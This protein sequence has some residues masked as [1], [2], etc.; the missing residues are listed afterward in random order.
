[1]G[2][3]P[4]SS[5]WS[6]VWGV[7]MPF[8]GVFTECDG[9]GWAYWRPGCRFR[10]CGR[11]QR[12]GGYGGYGGVRGGRGCS[13]GLW[14]ADGDLGWGGVGGWVWAGVWEAGAGLCLAFAMPVPVEGDAS[15]GEFGQGGVLVG[16]GQGGG[17][18]G[19]GCAGAGGGDDGAAGGCEGDLA[20][21]DWFAG[22]ASLDRWG[23]ECG[24]GAGG[25]AGEFD[26]GGPGGVFLGDQGR[27]G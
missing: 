25:R 17:Q 27:G 26:G 1:M 21:V 9:G 24:G 8:G 11:V 5:G 7:V 23:G 4:W 20:W 16:G 6:G 2:T 14:F 22:V 15:A 19:G 12:P 18:A 10:V 13:G 3:M